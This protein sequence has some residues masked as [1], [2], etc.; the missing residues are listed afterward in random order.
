MTALC[1]T[2]DMSI[3]AW[4]HRNCRFAAESIG[5]S[6]FF[7]P[8]YLNARNRDKIPPVLFH[9]TQ[10]DRAIQIL[11]SGGIKGNKIS[12]TENPAMSGPGPVVFVLNP[13]CILAKG[14]KL[15]PYLYG[16]G[17]LREAEWVVASPDSEEVD[18]G[19]K[20]IN[21]R[22]LVIVPFDCVIK[23]GISGSNRPEIAEVAQLAQSMGL[24]VEGDF[25]W[26]RYW[27]DRGAKMP[28]SAP[29][30]EN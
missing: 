21:S 27:G 13:Q 12:T 25:D 15:W 9:W 11:R 28:D 20:H 18:V 8:E 6:R 3:I 22:G 24:Q 29:L 26:G 23:V 2:I 5:P 19:Y 16:G 1:K 30:P 17:Y 10:P 14:L 4:V 7:T